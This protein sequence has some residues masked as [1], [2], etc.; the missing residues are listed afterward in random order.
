MSLA[1]EKSGARFSGLKDR[2]GKRNFIDQ[3]KASDPFRCK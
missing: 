3:I 2:K 1:P